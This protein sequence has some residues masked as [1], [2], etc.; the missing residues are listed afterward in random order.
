MTACI[1]ALMA[2][3]GS[4]KEVPLAN[5]PWLA[6]VAPSSP[7]FARIVHQLPDRIVGRNRP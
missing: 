3:A 7:I 5:I 2:V 6:A 1:P 4:A